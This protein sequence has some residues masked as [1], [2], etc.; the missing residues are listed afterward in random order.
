MGAFM[1]STPPAIQQSLRLFSVSHARQMRFLLASADR[2][3]NAS[4]LVSRLGLDDTE[5]NRRKI[6]QCAEDLGAE[7]ISGQ[8]GYR[9]VDRASVEEVRH[10]TAWMESQARKMQERAHQASIR[11]AISMPIA[12]AELAKER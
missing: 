3:L 10:F 12:L 11:K 4:D 7:I 2:W 6:R 9:H 1:T 5:S 8:R